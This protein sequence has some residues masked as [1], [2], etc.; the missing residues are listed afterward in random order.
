[1][2]DANE[3]LIRALM[4]RPVMPEEFDRPEPLGQ[5]APHMRAFGAGV[6]DPMGLPS[7]ALN[8]IAP[9]P[10]RD[11][12]MRRMQEARDESPIAAGAGSAVL[13]SLVG[14]GGLG[15]TAGEIAG[16]LPLAMQIGTGVGGVRDALFEP[17]KQR[18]PQAAY[19]PNGAY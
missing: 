17:A 10:G 11:W 13:P 16:A 2:A 15:L 8:K 6:V 4:A 14:L 1:M 18:R 5:L 12:Y 3:A 19:P 9:T 7:W